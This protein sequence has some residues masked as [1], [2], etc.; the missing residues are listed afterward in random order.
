MLKYFMCLTKTRYEALSPLFTLIVQYS[1][2]IVLYMLHTYSFNKE[3]TT[4]LY[5]VSQV[6]QTK[7]GGVYTSAFIKAINLYTMVTG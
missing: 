1:S 2:M 3:V 7:A 5:D 6:T 4:P